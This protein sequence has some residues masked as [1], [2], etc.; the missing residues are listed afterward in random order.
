MMGD[1]R[2]WIRDER[3]KY[4]RSSDDEVDS[5]LLMGSHGSICVKVAISRSKWIARTYP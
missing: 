1:Q 3:G 2:N 5:D 4:V